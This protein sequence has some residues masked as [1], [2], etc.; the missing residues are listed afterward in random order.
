MCHQDSLWQLSVAMAQQLILQ[1]QSYQIWILVGFTQCCP[2][3]FPMV[4]IFE[5]VILHNVISR[6]RLLPC[7]CWTRILFRPN[8][9]EGFVIETAGVVQHTHS[10]LFFIGFKLVQRTITN[11]FRLKNLASLIKNVNAKH[12]SN[13]RLTLEIWLWRLLVWIFFLY[14]VIGV[15][16][17]YP[18]CTPSESGF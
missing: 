5:S 10:K 3:N 18:V 4:L 13:I 12:S 15:W 14:L 6:T 8:P 17:Q 2:S 1:M 9:S 11:F 7:N 16:H